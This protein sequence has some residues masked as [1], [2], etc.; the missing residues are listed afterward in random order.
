ACPSTSVTPHDETAARN[1]SL[2]LT[3]SGALE[4]SRTK[5]WFRALLIARPTTPLERDRTVSTFVSLMGSSGV[6][7]VR[8]RLRPPRSSDTGSGPA[9]PARSQR[10]SPAPRIPSHAHPPLDRGRCGRGRTA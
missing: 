8:A 4:E 10:P 6:E 7:A 1:A 2:L 3:A 9:T 5:W